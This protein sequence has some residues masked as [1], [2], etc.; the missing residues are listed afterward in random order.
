[1]TKEI[2]FIHGGG[3]GAFA[4]DGKLADALQNA[5]G[6]EYTIRFPKMPNED[7]PEYPAWKETMLAEL[8]Q[9]ND[10][11]ILVGHSFGAS[12]LV[13]MLVETPEQ[14][15]RAAGLFLIAAP[16][17]GN[18]DWDVSAYELPE[19]FAAQL[20][21]GLPIFLYHSH[22]DEWVPFAHQAIYA[23][24]LPQATVRQFDRRGHQ[25]NDDL[26]EVAADIASLNA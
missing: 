12:L 2:L 7:S 22:D 25:F 8:A 16:Y 26:S 5:L 10:K 1:M 4:E 15:A 19:N 9:M 3:E 14:A 11:P 20:P 13:K 6:S 24:K 17:W 21:A 23:E 18:Q